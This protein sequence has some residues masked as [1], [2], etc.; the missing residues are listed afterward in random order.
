MSATE[1]IFIIHRNIFQM[2]TSLPIF[3][4]NLSSF[5]FQLIVIH[6]PRFLEIDLQQSVEMMTLHLGLLRI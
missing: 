6:W 4:F 1:I 3:E 5:N 2:F